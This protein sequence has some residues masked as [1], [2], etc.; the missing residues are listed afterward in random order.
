MALDIYSVTHAKE[1][2][3]LDQHLSISPAQSAEDMDL[4]FA[5][6][7]VVLGNAGT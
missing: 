4:R 5:Q 7:V 3:V 1:L 2:A 6:P